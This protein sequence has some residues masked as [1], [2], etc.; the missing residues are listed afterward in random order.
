MEIKLR[1]LDFK[2][3]HLK[4][5]LLD[6]DNLD[7]KTKALKKIGIDVNVNVNVQEKPLE[8]WLRYLSEL[9]NVPYTV[10]CHRDLRDVI[11]EDPAAMRFLFF[12][13]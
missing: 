10:P 4:I 13:A 11:E 2:D 9:N 12:L 7:L 6:D 3:Q 5:L 1:Y 8:A